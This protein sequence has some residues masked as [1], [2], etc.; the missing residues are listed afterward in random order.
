MTVSTIDKA[1]IL[2]ALPSRLLGQTA[3]L[4]GKVTSDALANKGVHRHQFSVLA[5]LDAFGTCS[6][7]DLCRRTDIDRSDMN[8]ALNGLQDRGAIARRTDPDN[9]RQNLVDITDNGRA[10]F[11]ELSAL[12][13]DAQDKAF[14]ALSLAE[15]GELVRLLGL[16]HDQLTS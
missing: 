5:T 8:A 16:V 7:A 1:P 14:A 4:V 15:R 11:V 13:V 12:A 3:A 9:R 6:Q 2:R 10:L